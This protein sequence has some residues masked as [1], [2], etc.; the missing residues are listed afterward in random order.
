[1]ADL[2]IGEVARLANV[3]H[4]ALRYYEEEGLIASFRLKNGHRRYDPAVLQQ[5][6]AI[7][8]AQKAGFT[9]AEIASLMR[10]FSDQAQPDQNWQAHIQ[11]KIGEA[12]TLL[13][14]VQEMRRL[15]QEL[16]SC[17]CQQLNDCVLVTNEAC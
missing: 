1:M 11:Q 15:L 17:E 16:S 6:K 10:N 4:S 7:H 14:S 9:I 5:L 13:A 8:T 12:D 2:T 3:R